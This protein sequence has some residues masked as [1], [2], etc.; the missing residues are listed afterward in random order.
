VSGVRSGPGGSLAP[1][2]CPKVMAARR[3]AYLL[4]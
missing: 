4:D 2:C 3:A 1:A